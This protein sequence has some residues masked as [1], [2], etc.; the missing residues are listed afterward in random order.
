MARYA[1]GDL[2]GCFV[3]FEQLLQRMEFDPL[4]DTLYLVGDLVNRGPASLPVLRWVMAQRHAVRMVLGNHDLHLLAVAAGLGKTKAGDTIDDVLQAP[5]CD[6]IIDFLRQQPLMISLG[7]TAI[8]HAGIWPGW[9]AAQAQALADEVS[10]AL[11]GPGWRDFL[12]AMYGN[13]P[14]LWQD[15]LQGVER[16]RFVVNAMTRMRF[17][18]TDGSLQLKYKGELEKAPAELYPWFDWPQRKQ[19]ARVVCG[20]WSA[21]GLRQNGSLCA[22][23]T[24]CIWGGA[25]TGIDLDSGRLY[26]VPA[27]RAYQALA[28]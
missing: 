14:A 5:D 18:N 12:A 10:V 20:H 8:V 25:L 21:L 27:H 13:Q 23:D 7:R 17:V 4:Q 1:I 16:L 15:D 26:Q 9:S 2:Q 22:L 3:E 11:C 6:A 24:G 19:D 28:E